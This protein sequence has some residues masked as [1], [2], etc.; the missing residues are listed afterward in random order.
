MVGG[1]GGVVV[2]LR[3]K[4]NPISCVHIFLN[5]YQKRFWCSKDWY[6]YMYILI[7]INKIKNIKN[8]MKI[9]ND[10]YIKLQRNIAA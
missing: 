5:T 10:P 6:I 2:C 4:H 9:K 1:G 8:C 3:C 7:N